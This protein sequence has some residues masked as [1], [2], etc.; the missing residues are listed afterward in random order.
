MCLSRG[1]NELSQ[2]L[3]LIEPQ[4]LEC[5]SKWMNDCGYHLHSNV[6]SPQIT[7][8]LYFMANVTLLLS[9][10]CYY[11]HLCIHHIL[12]YGTIH[13]RFPFLQPIEQWFSNFTMDKSHWSLH[14]NTNG[15]AP[16]WRASDKV[17]LKICIF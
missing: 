7:L 14:W 2:G 8:H 11:C 9:S 12:V 3:W 16:L 6:F 13:N 5:F 4:H 17:G 10:P 1:L 15:G